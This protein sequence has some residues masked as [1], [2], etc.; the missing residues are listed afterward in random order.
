MKKRLLYVLMINALC[1]F[2]FSTNANAQ[3]KVGAAIIHG[4]KINQTGF[5]ADGVIYLTNTSRL[6][7]DAGIFWPPTDDRRGQRATR[8][9]LDAN[10]HLNISSNKHLDHYFLTGLNFTTKD[11]NE[12]TTIP[13][14]RSQL[15]INIGTGIQYKLN[16][17]D[18]FTEAKFVAGRFNQFVYSTGFRFRLRWL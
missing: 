11:G 8:S 13:E 14:R 9:E 15:G 16:M 12:F 17:G 6:Q 3:H 7:I 18:F 4:D 5:R 10:I 1:V 2:V